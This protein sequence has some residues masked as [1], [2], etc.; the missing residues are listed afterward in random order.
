MMVYVWG[1]RNAATQMSFLGLF[2]FTA[3][4][5]PWVLLIFSA[6]MRLNGGGRASVG[7]DRRSACYFLKDVYP[8]MTG[9]EPLATPRWCAMFG[10]RRRTVVDAAVLPGASSFRPR[11]ASVGD[12]DE[13]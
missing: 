10:A 6:L 1:R 5:L 4:Y 8:D 3:P 12:L 7:N 9:R 2:N 11:L 13:E